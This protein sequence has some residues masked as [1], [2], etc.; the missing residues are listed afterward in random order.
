ML[1]TI[2]QNFHLEKIFWI[3]KSK[4]KYMI[5]IGLI[6]GALAGGFTYLTRVDTYAAQ[7][8][9]YVYSKP[10]YVNDNGINL[11][12]SDLSEASSLLNSYMQ[13]LKSRS[14]LTSIIEEAELDP[15]EYTPNYL[16]RNIQANAVGGT[17]VFKVTVYDEN[18][19]NAMIIANTIGKLAPEKIIS[20]VKSGG[21]EILDEAILPTS[22]YQRTSVTL[23]SLVGVFAGGVMAALFFLIRGLLDTRYRRIYEIENMFNIPI[24]GM[25][26]LIDKKNEDGKPDVLLG[27]D[28]EFVLKEAYNDIRTNLLFL[29]QADCPVFA[30]TGADYS[31]GKTTNSINVAVSFSMMG[32]KT[33]LIDADLRNGNIADEFKITEKKGLSDYLAKLSDL[34]ISKNVVENLDV[35]TTGTIPPNPTDLLL[36]ARWKEMI[37]KFKGEYDVII[38]DTPS[39]GVVADGVEI[40]TVAD[41]FIIV[42]REFV[43]RF[44]REELIVRR[45]EAVD[46]NICG[47][48]YNGISVKSEDFNHKEYVNGGEYGKRSSTRVQHRKLFKKK[49]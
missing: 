32:K 22:P 42:I 24:L 1:K 43:T 44:E 26:P 23:M 11:S 15:R 29:G 40:N 28:S 21:I 8:S 13:I 16:A 36:S 19:Y 46:A 30:V 12:S 6:F 17:A 34:K 35:I 4:L 39:I 45:L 14:F 9:L 41:A 49:S 33:L 7:I 5:L 20:I 25:V 47:F 31:E 10:D 48:I 38:I 2:L 27:P 3:I 18:P 37:E